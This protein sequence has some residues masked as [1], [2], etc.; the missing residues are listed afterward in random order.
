MKSSPFPPGV[1]SGGVD[2][3]Y[4]KEESQGCPWL[5]QSLSSERERKAL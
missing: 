3:L 5:I 4:S 2:V 1:G